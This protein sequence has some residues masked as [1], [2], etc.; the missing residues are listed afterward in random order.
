MNLGN[1]E[2]VALNRITQYNYKIKPTADDESPLFIEIIETVD[3][4]ILN[5]IPT[6]EVLING[7]RTIKHQPETEV[8]ERFIHIMNCIDHYIESVIINENR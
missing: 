6:Y 1:E 7:Y 3:L 5:S 2:S 8:P 4:S